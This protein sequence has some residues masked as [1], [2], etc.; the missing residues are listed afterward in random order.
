VWQGQ[1]TRHVRQALEQEGL[2]Q[3]RLRALWSA[4]SPVSYYQ[5][6]AGPEANG[7]G[8]NVLIVYANYDMTF[9]KAYSLQVVEAFRKYGVRFEPRVL[10]C[11]HYTTGETPYKFIAAGTWVPSSIAR[12]SA[13]RRKGC[14]NECRRG[15]EKQRRRGGSF[16]LAHG[17]VCTERVVV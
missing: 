15:A 6:F 9:P 16:A 4:I 2:T 5:Q 1:S 3:E 11:G 17:A 7:P 10:P 14:R 13:A 12:Q 8:K